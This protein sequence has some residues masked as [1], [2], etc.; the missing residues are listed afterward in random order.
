MLWT[1]NLQP[2][3]GWSNISEMI[4]YPVVHVS[5]FDAV[6]FCQWAGK[7]LPSEYEWEY[8]ARAKLKGE[9]RVTILTSC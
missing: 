1:L 8:A 7:R 4:D 3:G 6:A 2:F 9:R 5:F